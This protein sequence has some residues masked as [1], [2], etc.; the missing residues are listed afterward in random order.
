MELIEY[1]GFN[2]IFIGLA[3]ENEQYFMIYGRTG[4][5]TL[6]LAN[7]EIFAYGL[8]GNKIGSFTTDQKYELNIPF[9]SN[10]NNNS[11][12]VIQHADKRLYKTCCEILENIL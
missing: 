3:K 11:V 10:L 8:R 7:D 1:R 5:V 6:S 12:I 4:L 2:N 9:V